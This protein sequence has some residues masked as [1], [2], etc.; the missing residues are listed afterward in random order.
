M[1][2]GN[3]GHRERLRERFQRGGLDGFLDHEVLEF[4]LTYAIP[5]R[6]VKTIAKDLLSE[7]GSLAAVFDAPPESLKRMNGLGPQAVLFMGLIPCLIQRYQGNRWSKENKRTFNSTPDV[8]SF[9]SPLLRAERNEVFMLLAL[10]SRNV[11]NG[12]EPIQR[13]TIN[14]TAVF[15][16]LIVEASLK[17]RATAIILAHNHPGGDP[18]PSVADRQLTTK[19][20]RMLQEMDILVHDHVIIAGDQYFSFAENGGIE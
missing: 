8:V 16:R 19:L 18:N 3:E 11:L 15:P 20:R 5:R 12:I 2:I 7:F 14:R 4:V 17:H 1:N 13:G 10:D 9:L 6:D